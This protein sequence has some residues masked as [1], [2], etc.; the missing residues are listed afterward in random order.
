LYYHLVDQLLDWK[1]FVVAIFFVVEGDADNLLE[2][3]LVG[4]KHDCQ[5]IIVAMS[6]EKVLENAEGA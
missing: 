4:Q 2:W 3:L 1:G 6:Q 5:S